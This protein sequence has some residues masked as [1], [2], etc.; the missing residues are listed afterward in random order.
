MNL[1]M[2]IEKLLSHRREKNIQSIKCFNL[3]Y[4][5]WMAQGW[6]TLFTTLFA[7]N[8]DLNIFHVFGLFCYTWEYFPMVCICSNIQVTLRYSVCTFECPLETAIRRH[9]MPCIKLLTKEMFNRPANKPARVDIQTSMLTPEGTGRW[10][11]NQW[12]VFLFF[13]K[14]MEVDAQ[15]SAAVEVWEWIIISSYT[16]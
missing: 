16:L 4:S 3:Q 10:V 11:Q 12:N 9:D 2:N 13:T 7:D 8:C 5:K 1:S 6:W 14:W 15:C